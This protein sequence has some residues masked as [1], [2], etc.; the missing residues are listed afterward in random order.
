MVTRNQHLDQRMNWFDRQFLRAQ[1]FADES[2]YQVD[3]LRR[4]LRA[5]HTPGIAEGLG[6]S[7]QPGDGSVTV[8]PGTAIDDQGREIVLITAPQAL[9]LPS[10][11]TSCELYVSYA[12]APTG[13]SQ[14]P[15]V[16]GY[17]RITEAPQFS[18]R[19]T[20]PGSQPVPQS[21]VLLAALSLKGGLLN[22]APDVSGQV[23]AGAA[24]GDVAAFSV[25][26][27]RVGQPA[28]AW[29]RLT[30]SGP[31]QLSLAGD[32]RLTSQGSAPG[33]LTM[34]G[35][36][37]LNDVTLSGP[38]QQVL[39]LAGDMKLSSQGSARGALSVAGPLTL[40]GGPQLT[41]ASNYQLTLAGDLTLAGQGP[42]RGMLTLPGLL[43]VNGGLR[44]GTDAPISAVSRDAGLSAARDTAVPTEAAVKA[45]VDHQVGFQLGSVYFHNV[46]AGQDWQRNTPVFPQPFARPP[47]VFIA[48]I[49]AEWPARSGGTTG[50]LG[51]LVQPTEPAFGYDM[52][53]ENVTPTQFDIRVASSSGTVAQLGVAWLA[54]GQLA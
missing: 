21:G 25:T 51:V 47:K 22:T 28:S 12:E 1:D 36:L 30:A 19:E 4:H 9:A 6:V 53:T 32:L 40:G 3:R 27:K 44:F 37:T 17:T 26:L 14:D 29:P 48:T 20:A 50:P 16:T 45:Y 2:D 41:G 10:S 49:C 43:T 42:A 13:P 18:F 8:G 24:V 46:V 35:P 38:G 11:S 52:R 34:P 33:Q 54:F 15:G 23:K 39:A 7:G 5:L 31:S